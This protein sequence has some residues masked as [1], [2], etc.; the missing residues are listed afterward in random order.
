MKQLPLTPDPEAEARFQAYLQKEDERKARLCELFD[1]VER[2][3][4]KIKKP[5]GAIRKYERYFRGVAYVAQKR[6]GSILFHRHSGQKLGWI[7]LPPEA[8]QLLS[9]DDDL[10]VIFGLRGQQWRVIAVLFIG[11]VMSP[12]NDPGLN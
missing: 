9:V 6:S 5:A 4:R 3:E 1:E 12:E 2:L 8:C 10:G 7:A 11:S